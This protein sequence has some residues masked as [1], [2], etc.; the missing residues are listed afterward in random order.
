MCWAA[1]S[2]TLG[3]AGS[4]HIPYSGYLFPPLLALLG[5]HLVSLVRRSAV[6]GWGASVVSL[7]GACTILAGHRWFPGIHWLLNIGIL[8]VFG[9]SLWNSFAMKRKLSLPRIPVQTGFTGWAP[10]AS[11][12]SAKAL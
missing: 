9:G 5:L 12:S 4:F 8:L 2:T 10:E 1:Y 3:I 11:S 7:A 6:V